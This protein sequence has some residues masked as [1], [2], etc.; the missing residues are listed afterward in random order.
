ML[1]NFKLCAAEVLFEK[2][3]LDCYF[4]SLRMRSNRF[5]KAGPRP[6]PVAASTQPRNCFPAPQL[7][8]FLHPQAGNFADVV[9][10]PHLLLIQ[11]IRNS[12]Q[13]GLLAAC[14]S[15]RS[16]FAAQVRKFFPVMQHR[17]GYAS[18]THSKKMRIAVK[19]SGT[20]SCAVRSG[21]EGCAHDGFSRG[22]A[23]GVRPFA[24]TGSTAVSGFRRVRNC[25]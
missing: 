16:E 19:R 4:S 14:Q 25:H 3:L 22:I 6:C 24:P 7:H 5:S 20:S 11:S 21:N 9:R 18:R 10:R 1:P 23:R 15:W 12:P 8:R 17:M 2:E 13:D